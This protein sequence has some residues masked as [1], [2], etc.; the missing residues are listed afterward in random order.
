MVEWLNTVLAVA[1][2]L[3]ALFALWQTSRANR[4]SDEANNISRQANTIA[5]QAM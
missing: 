4:H 5:K 2:V 1:G 3:I